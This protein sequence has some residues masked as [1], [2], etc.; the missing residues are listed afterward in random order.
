MWCQ[1]FNFTGVKY[2]FFLWMYQNTK[3][4]AVHIISMTST[5]HGLYLA[6]QSDYYYLVI[7]RVS[8]DLAKIPNKEGSFPVVE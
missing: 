3:I 7:P 4:K 1:S 8:S 2:G 5:I 6:R